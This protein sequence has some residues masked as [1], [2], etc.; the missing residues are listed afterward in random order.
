M[1]RKVSLFSGRD[2]FDAIEEKLREREP[3]TPPNPLLNS[4]YDPLLFSSN[5]FAI[6]IAPAVRSLALD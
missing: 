6:V 1:L 4:G 3:T 2:C 5:F